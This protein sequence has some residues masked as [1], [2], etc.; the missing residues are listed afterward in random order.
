M[1][2]IITN[3]D[4]RLHVI[5]PDANVCLAYSVNHK[6]LTPQ[7]K[8]VH[9]RTAYLEAVEYYLVSTISS[10]S[11]YMIKAV[12]N[13]TRKMMYYVLRDAI[14]R[15]GPASKDKK[16]TDEAITCK[17]LQYVRYHIAKLS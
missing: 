3:I 8:T 10:G 4:S 13:E 2:K 5:I 7:K 12:E 16:E 9:V 11:V 14:R 1:Q 6:Y 15:S 17:V